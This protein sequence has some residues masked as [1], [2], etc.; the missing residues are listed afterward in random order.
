M[1]AAPSCP[2]EARRLAAVKRLR[3]LGTPAEERF[4]AITRMARAQLDVPLACLDIVGDKMVWLKSV[5]GFDGLEGA[6]KDSYCHYT[7][8]DDGVCIVRDARTDPRVH[9]SILADSWV[10]YAGVPLHFDGQRVGVLC[11]GDSKSRELT[12][13]QYNTLSNLAA[14]AERELQTIALSE[15]QTALPET[16]D[17]LDLKARVDLLTHLWNRE[18]IL[19]VAA[20]E[21][22][23][24]AAILLIHIEDLAGI[25][26]DLGPA[27]GEQVLRAAAERLRAALGP[28]DAVG[29][30]DA[31][32]FMAVLPGATSAEA[33]LVSEHVCAAISSAPVGF[34]RKSIPLACRAGHVVS[35]GSLTDTV[36]A[37]VARAGQALHLEAVN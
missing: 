35:T 18:A 20:V 30:Y 24:P 5:Q 26:A 10:F 16:D 13:A 34:E 14:L 11:V 36:S 2:D 19:A 32:I 3:L 29:R 7:V 22:R 33:R 8:L 15:V 25:T 17:E 6:R 21:C 37:L 4:D 28:F 9:D 12:A 23:K 27:A 1:P 31:D